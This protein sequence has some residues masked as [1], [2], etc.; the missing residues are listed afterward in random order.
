MKVAKGA[1]RMCRVIATNSFEN[2]KLPLGHLRRQVMYWGV[3]LTKTMG[4]TAKR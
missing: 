1:D 2:N 4:I 3:F